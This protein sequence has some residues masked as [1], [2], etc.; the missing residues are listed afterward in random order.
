MTKQL[1]ILLP[2]I[3]MAALFALVFLRSFVSWRLRSLRRKETDIDL[4]RPPDPN[5]RKRFESKTPTVSDPRS[6]KKI[7]W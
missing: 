3:L 5:Q 6:R 1:V 7:R 4:D 2:L